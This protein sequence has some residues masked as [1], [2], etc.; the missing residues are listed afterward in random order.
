MARKKM[1]SKHICP[2]LEI[3]ATALQE[4]YEKRRVTDEPFRIVDIN[5]GIVFDIEFL[6]RKEKENSDG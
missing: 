2:E 1:F 4:Y 5:G 6:T 3:I